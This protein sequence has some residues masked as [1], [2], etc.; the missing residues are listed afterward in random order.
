M[1]EVQMTG[2][3]T[4]GAAQVRAAISKAARRTGVDF[5]YLLAQARLESSLDPHARARTSSAAGLYQFTRDTWLRTLDRHAARH[6][7]EWV[8]EAIEK[9]RVNDEGLRARLLALRYD[10]EA[11]ALMAAE[12]ARDNSLALSEVLGRQPDAAELYLG[13]FLGADGASRFLR[14]LAVTPEESAAALLP[15]AAAANRA[16]FYAENGVPRSLAGVMEVIR[17]RMQ[18]A[19]SDDDQA[20]ASVDPAPVSPSAAPAMGPIARAFHQ[21]RTELPE[22]VARRS[23]ADT[24]LSAFAVRADAGAEQTMPAT[25]RAAYGKLRSLGL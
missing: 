24:L 5:D 1:S 21:V 8:G 15:K 6:G 7:L 25:V 2:A 18:A 20:W 9:G 12:L 23:M 17:A 3:L 19:M 11:S 13:H 4:P 16:I 14:A 10:A 22:P